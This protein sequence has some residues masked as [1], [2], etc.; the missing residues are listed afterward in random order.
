MQSRLPKE[1]AMSNGNDGEKPKPPSKPAEGRA[2]PPRNEIVP[3]A[4]ESILRDISVDPRDPNVSKALEISLTMMFSGSLP[5]APPPILKEYGNI[6][7]ELIDKLIKWTEDQSAHRREL[8]RLRTEGSER[9]LN[10]SQWIAAVVAVGG[11]ILAAF[12]GSYSNPNGATAAI[13]IAIALVSVG[14]P[15]AAIWLAHN[16]R[17]SPL[18]TPLTPQMPKPPEV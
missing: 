8:E 18:Y 2:E 14:G 1:N 4:L 11:L 13:A 16:V 17:R 5:L 9:R 3:P 15:T 6:R 10:R 12:V 7:P